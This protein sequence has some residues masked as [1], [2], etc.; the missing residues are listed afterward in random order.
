MPS[1]NQAVHKNFKKLMKRE[2]IKTPQGIGFIAHIFL[3]VKDDN[4]ILVYLHI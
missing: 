1:L 3:S 2:I 4:Q